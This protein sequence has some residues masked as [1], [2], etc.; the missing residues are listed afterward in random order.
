MYD[1]IYINFYGFVS[2]S[3][4]AIPAPYITDETAM[5]R[6]FSMISPAFSPS[7]AYVPS[8]NDGVFLYTDT[9]VVVIRWK[10]SVQ[11]NANNSN[12]NFALYLYPDGH[13]EFRYGL[14]DTGPVLPSVYTG[15]S[16][17]DSHN[18]NIK[19]EWRADN[20]DGS[21]I[22]Y[23]PL[24]FPAGLELSPDGLLKLEGSDPA[25]IFSIP[26]MVT[27]EE[28]MTGSK[29]LA[30]SHDLQLTWKVVSGMD[31]HLVS[32]QPSNLTLT[33]KNTGHTALPDA[34]A[35][36]RSMDTLCLVTD[37]VISIP[38]LPP[39]HQAT[40]NKVFDFT[41]A[42]PLSC[43]Y[44]VRFTLDVQAGIRYWHHLIEIPVAAPKLEFLPPQVPD[45]HNNRLDPGEIADLMVRL[46]NLGNMGVDHVT[47]LLESFDTLV[48]VLSD[49]VQ[50]IGQSHPLSQQET[51]F[52]L[53]ASRKAPPGHNVPF[54]LTAF[55]DTLVLNRLNFSLPV[56]KKAVALINL[57][58]ANTSMVAMQKAMDSLGVGYDS[59]RALNTPLSNYES[60][61]LILGH[62][63]LGAHSIN[64]AEAKL[65]SQYLEE[66]GNL[67]MEGY[68]T[69]YYTNNTVL[70]PYFKY[71]TDH[72]S[73]YSFDKAIG[74]SGTLTDAM[75]FDNSGY[76]DFCLFTFV[77]QEPA[78]STFVN[79][80]SPARNLEIVY[81]GPGYKTIGTFLEFGSLTGSVEP[82]TLHA[83]MQRYLEFFDINLSGPYVLFHADK[84]NVKPGFPV[85]FTDD[86]YDDILSWQW[87][88]PGGDPATS[89]EANPTV[90][91]DASGIFDVKLTVSDGVQAR[92][93][94]RKNYIVVN[95]PASM[96][97][98]DNLPR[99]SVYPNPAKDQAI[100]VWSGPV[101]SNGTL[102][103]INSIGQTVM[104][105]RIAGGTLPNRWDLNLS[106]LAPG[107]YFIKL[108]TASG[109][110]FEKLIVN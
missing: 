80:S 89:N 6:M 72:C 44:P 4:Q 8:K 56:G 46:N 43:D 38:A 31:G 9:T 49:P 74:V 65:L 34:M 105:K 18:F 67:Y 98:S 37:S 54:R 79:T 11:D 15:V 13:F 3:P 36:L 51:G 1:S 39:G 61:F 110:A 100:V 78:Y 50:W 35:T 76:P 16:K 17:G 90:M 5:M 60:I 83:L 109:T 40:F 69:W 33:L 53:K 30:L 71:T 66:H 24:P 59:L 29:W 41:V 22:R 99:V 10:T 28:N 19:T 2:F 95:F 55:N 20:L 77:P 45:G 14:M 42:D 64:S 27:D 52:R 75:S 93:L 87:E 21:A 63:T 57:S 7:Y 88:F 92:S 101:H 58:A 108:N 73:L 81:P 107:I 25:Q 106:G 32:G 94:V 102:S 26:V 23:L 104:E 97:K 48:K 86:S 70:H 103:L 68:F 62:S 85:V 91:Y 12:N 96:D 84:T 47:V 82:S